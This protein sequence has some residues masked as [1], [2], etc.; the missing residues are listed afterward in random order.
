MAE[1]LKALK[2]YTGVAGRLLKL[3]GSGACT[4][5]Q[6]AAAC[7]VDDSY[8]SQLC[9][10]EDFQLQIQ[11]KI[12]KS[13]E[14]A[15]EIDTNYT[16]LEQTLSQRLA[17]QAKMMFNPDQILR[18]LKFANEAKRKIQPIQKNAE[19]GMAPSN[20]TSILVLP[21]VIKQTFI[22]SPNNEVVSVDGRDLVT[23]NSESMKTLIQNKPSQPALPKNETTRILPNVIQGQ[24]SEDKWSNL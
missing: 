2:E 13:V 21:Q 15:N 5:T 6:A 7:G 24:R 12:N 9:G 8:V 19:G 11:E 18:V 10:E 20:H 17:D 14:V 1:E 22:V 16:S 23:L 3:L 4:Q